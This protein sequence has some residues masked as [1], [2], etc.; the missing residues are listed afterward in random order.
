M[1]VNKSQTK[2]LFHCKLSNSKDLSHILSSLQYKD[3]EKWVL[4][5]INEKGIKMSIQ[6]LSKTTKISTFL[7]ADTF[8][9]YKYKTDIVKILLNFRKKLYFVFIY[10]SKIK[11][12]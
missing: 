7:K 1:S 2:Y 9:E 6:G 11:Y 10:Q 12:D 3:S 5:E 4:W 8:S